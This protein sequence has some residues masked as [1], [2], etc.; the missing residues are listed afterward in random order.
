MGDPQNGWFILENPNPKWMMTGGTPIFGNPQV[1]Y[2]KAQAAAL[3][4]SNMKS[5]KGASELLTSPKC[6]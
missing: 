2:L 1:F 4:N 5:R 6:P 3:A